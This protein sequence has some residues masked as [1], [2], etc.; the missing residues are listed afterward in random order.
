MHRAQQQ[1]EV[2]RQASE[3]VSSSAEVYGAVQQED[4]IARA[5]EIMLMHVD[6]L[7]KNYERDHHDLEE[8]RKVLDENNLRPPNDN[9]EATD[10]M[11]EAVAET[12]ARPNS[13]GR[14]VS[15]IH[16]SQGCPTNT[17]GAAL[18]T[19]ISSFNAS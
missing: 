11:L 14:S 18:V 17:L 16:P 8:A 2:V 9:A 10:Q 12:S 15:V 4:R 6:N 1:V 19:L 13:R 5:I 7:R 3:R